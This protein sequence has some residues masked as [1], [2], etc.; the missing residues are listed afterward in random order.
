[1]V[2]IKNKLN[3]KFIEFLLI[4]L[5]ITLLF[6]VTISELTIVVVLSLSIFYS[7]KI[8]LIKSFNE[9]IIIFLCLFWFYLFINFSINYENEPS[10]LRTIFFGRFIF[11]VI[12]LNLIINNFEINLEK[13]FKFW[14]FILIIVCFDLFLQFY[15]QK[16]ILGF[17]SF[18]LTDEIFRLGGFMNDELKIS[19]IIYNFGL[20]IFAYFSFNNQNNSFHK[21]NFLLLIL[22]I[23]TIFITGER[24]HFIS[25]ILFLF[26]FIIFGELNF[27]KII[28]IFSCFLIFI[29]FFV[30]N[31]K[32]LSNRMIFNINDKVNLFKL[33]KDKSYLNKDSRYFAHYSVAYQIFEENK[34]FGVGLK[35]FRKFCNNNKYDKDVYPNWIDRKCSTHPHNFYFEIIA[36]LGGIGLLFILSFLVYSFYKFL[37]IYY[38]S[39]NKF[40][41]FNIF[42]ILIYF[43][44]FIPRGS[45]FNN[46]NAIIF[47][48]IFSILYSSYNKSK[49]IN[50]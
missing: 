22:I 35:N 45:F 39:K 25:S 26:F 29:S 9:P 19:N 47:W 41:L 14:L 15:T 6:S 48:T 32:E 17:Q 8:N 21:Y 28:I 16:N 31:K 27:K 4:I 37:K 10:I 13:I 46:W 40:L 44:P 5:P 50:D 23:L 1:M 43:V 2:S 12:C 18:K 30:L 38:I 24:A 42:I 36:E 34:Y 49:K 3:I 11:L 7:N 33:E 20:L